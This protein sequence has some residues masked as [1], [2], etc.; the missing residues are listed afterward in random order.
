MDSTVPINVHGHN[1]HLMSLRYTT[2]WPK[3][4]DGINLLPYL[5]C[6]FLSNKSITAF[7]HNAAWGGCLDVSNG[8][9]YF[10]LSGGT[11]PHQRRN[12]A[13]PS[14][15]QS[16]I[17]RSGMA[18]L[19]YQILKR[20]ASQA[21]V[22]STVRHLLWR[23]IAPPEV[24]L[25]SRLQHR[26]SPV[27]SKLDSNMNKACVNG[28]DGV[29]QPPP[30]DRFQHGVLIATERGERIAWP[31]EEQNPAKLKPSASANY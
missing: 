6:Q 26:P 8:R 14:N 28:H 23:H 1:G 21:N 5:Y 29:V 12:E 16:P 7:D 25:I 31:S 13:P 30:L 22:L 20:C 17:T 15:F 11:L 10:L 2:L 24:P 4:K 18:F 9:L 19:V 3:D 27:F